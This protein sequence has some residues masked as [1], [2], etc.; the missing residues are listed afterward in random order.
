M[1]AIKLFKSLKLL[2]SE[3]IIII[4]LDY[5]EKLKVAA[6]TELHLSVCQDLGQTPEDRIQ[7]SE[8][9]RRFI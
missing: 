7:N 5:L 9:N 2:F 3:N 6:V 1:L 8:E 4:V